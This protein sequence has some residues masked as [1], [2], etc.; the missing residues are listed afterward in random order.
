[1]EEKSREPEIHDLSTISSPD[2]LSD[3]H[4]NPSHCRSLLRVRV[5][6]ALNQS[7]HF[8]ES[9][10]LFLRLHVVRFQNFRL[11]NLLKQ[12]AHIEDTA[13]LGQLSSECQFGSDQIVVDHL[14]GAVGSAGMGFF[15]TL[16][17]QLLTHETATHWLH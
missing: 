14:D 6:G 4:H 3:H 10:W 16:T 5:S 13:L 17:A 7:A 1:M 8:V 11:Q 9:T 2:N 12:A 15:L